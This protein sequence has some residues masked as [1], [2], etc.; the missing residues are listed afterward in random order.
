MRCLLRVLTAYHSK[1]L[2]LA[3]TLTRTSQKTNA[4]LQDGHVGV[5]DDNLAQRGRGKRAQGH[6]LELAV[7]LPRALLG[8]TKAKG[9]MMNR[10]EGQ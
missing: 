6:G 1:C 9:K 10:T 4:Y 8:S 2:T 5:D 3:K 7:Q